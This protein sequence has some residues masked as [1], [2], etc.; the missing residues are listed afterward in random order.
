MKPTEEEIEELKDIHCEACKGRWTVDETGCYNTCEGFA[1]ALQ[2]LR[3]E[4]RVEKA[5][6]EAMS[7]VT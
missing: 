2:D 7:Y 3:C 1:E 5:V 6:A 4:D